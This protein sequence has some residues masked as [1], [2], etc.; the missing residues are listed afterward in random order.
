M[1]Y[2]HHWNVLIVVI[3]MLIAYC[4][5]VAWEED[6]IWMKKVS[7]KRHTAT[8][9]QYYVKSSLTATSQ[10]SSFTQNIVCSRSV[11]FWEG[12]GNNLQISTYLPF[13]VFIY[14]FCKNWHLDA[15]IE[16]FNIWIFLFCTYS[17]AY[18]NRQQWTFNMKQNCCQA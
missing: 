9:S 3:S 17:T 2:F 11:G 1:S 15:K 5:T 18:G 6:K 14:H 10:F 13:V 4:T 8:Y 7:F 16:H 12:A